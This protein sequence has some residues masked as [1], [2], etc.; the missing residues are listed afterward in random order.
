[1]KRAYKFLTLTGL[2]AVMCLFL[3]MP[4]MAQHRGGGGGGGGGHASGG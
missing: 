4:A 3:A 1:M 2:S